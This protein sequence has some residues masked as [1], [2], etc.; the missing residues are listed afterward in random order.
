MAVLS[1]PN[2]DTPVDLLLWAVYHR[3]VTGLVEATYAANP[4]LAELDLWP[5]AGTQFTV[6]PPNVT[7]PV[8][9]PVLRLY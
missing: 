8:P 4:G 2:N 1:V 5:P 7:A 6:T 3:Q 9:P